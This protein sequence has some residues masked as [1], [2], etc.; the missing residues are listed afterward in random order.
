MLRDASTIK[1]VTAIL[2]EQSRKKLVSSFLFN[3]IVHFEHFI[4]V[5][6]VI[7]ITLIQ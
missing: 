6:R 2:K 7:N 4:D 3:S 1:I 5:Q